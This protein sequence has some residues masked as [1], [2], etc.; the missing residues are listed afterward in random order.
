M[1]AKDVGSSKLSARETWIQ[2][3]T[4]EI[5][6]AEQKLKA[7]KEKKEI[8]DKVIG[9]LW[10]DIIK[11]ESNS[12]KNNPFT[13]RKLLLLKKLKNLWKRLK[14]QRKKWPNNKKN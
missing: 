3:T 1:K 4:F 11:A 9:K 6:I 5:I 2:D 12:P 7:L 8:L 10:I 14:L 13:K